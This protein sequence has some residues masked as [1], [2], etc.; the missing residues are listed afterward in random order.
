MLCA[1][2]IVLQQYISRPGKGQAFPV[3]TFFMAST[4]YQTLQQA[5][6]NHR[7]LFGLLIDPDRLTSAE[8]DHL[9]G[10]LQRTKIDL[11]L[12]GGSLLVDDQLDACLERLRAET[13]LPLLLFPGSL[14]QISAKAD[15]LL[16]LSLI[17][18][19]NPELLI[20]QHVTAAPY[21]RASGLELIPT[22]YLLVD[23][24]QPTTASYMSHTHPIPADK[25]EI[26]VCTAMAGEM[27]GM[28]CLY[29]DAGSGAQHPI[30]TEMIARVREKTTGPLIVGGGIRTPQA[31]LARLQA[32]ADM[33]VVGNAIE[34]SPEVLLDMSAAMHDF[35]S[36][37]QGKTI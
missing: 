25:P 31:V 33:V 20:G 30:S 12:I 19:R 26:A 11:L 24:G 16:L 9:L 21:L 27:L 1:S 8:L 3:K 7:K 34:K 4:V 29:L 13:D 10:L 35:N 32:G 18:G 28:R 5:R 6:Q 23:G 22:G 17:S 36:R 15:A 14:L 2:I 37:T